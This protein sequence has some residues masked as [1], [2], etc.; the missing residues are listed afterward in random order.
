MVSPGL[1]SLGCARQV[2]EDAQLSAVKEANADADAVRSFGGIQ[3]SCV[4][5]RK[6][7]LPR[8]AQAHLSHG[9]LLPHS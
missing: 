3:T 5:T 6:R 9:R 1:I 7:I 4:L 2:S 8:P